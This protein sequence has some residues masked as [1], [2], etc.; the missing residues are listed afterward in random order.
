PAGCRSNRRAQLERC[1]LMAVHRN[2]R[3]D[4]LDDVDERRAVRSA[5][6]DTDANPDAHA[7]PDARADGR[8]HDAGS[9]CVDWWRALRER[10]L[11]AWSWAGPVADAHTDAHAH[12]RTDRRLHDA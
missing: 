9:L 7:D 1:L 5:T 10:R 3:S 11:A 8:L 12:A 2:R 4:H 6:A